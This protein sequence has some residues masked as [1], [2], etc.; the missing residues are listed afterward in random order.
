MYLIANVLYWLAKLPVKASQSV[1]QFEVDG[2]VFEMQVLRLNTTMKRLES[3]FVHD[4]RESLDSFSL[5][6]KQPVGLSATPSLSTYTSSFKVFAPFH[7]A[8][9]SI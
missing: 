3:G 8:A 6:A 4:Q 1:K 9:A 2:C 5:F 7:Y